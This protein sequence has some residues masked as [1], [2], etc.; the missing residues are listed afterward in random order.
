MVIVKNS[1][2][3]WLASA[4]SIIGSIVA[5]FIFPVLEDSLPIF[6][7]MII[8]LTGM[9]LLLYSMVDRVN[10]EQ[11]KLEEKIEKVEEGVEEKIR[12]VEELIETKTEIKYLKDK[13]V[14]IE[15]KMKNGS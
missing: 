12:R 1:L 7:V 10:E 13:L 11:V 14:R 3:I 4:L 9:G 8:V 15:E 6:V 5:T 2:P